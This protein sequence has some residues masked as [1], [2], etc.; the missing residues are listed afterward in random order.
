MDL[1]HK[2]LKVRDHPFCETPN[3]DLAI[4]Y[5]FL[6]NVK[7]FIRLGSYKFWFYDSL[8]NKDPY[9]KCFVQITIKRFYV[10]AFILNKVSEQSFLYR[11]SQFFC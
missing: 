11:L 2:L 5:C 8:W 6:F 10:K 1:N 9:S 4:L 3:K 7:S